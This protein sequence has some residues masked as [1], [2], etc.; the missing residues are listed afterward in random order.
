ML[1]SYCL[2]SVTV[3]SSALPLHFHLLFMGSPRGAA[4]DGSGIS[5]TAFR[6]CCARRGVSK[7]IFSA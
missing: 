7:A 1:W 6:Q 3:S 5:T 2:A 4:D